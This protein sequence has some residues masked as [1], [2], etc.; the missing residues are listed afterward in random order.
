MAWPP[1]GGEEG[2]VGTVRGVCR[3]VLAGCLLA[4][5][6]AAAQVPA[7]LPDRV[8]FRT[9]TES[10]NSHWYVALRDGRIWVKPNE[11]IGLRPPGHWALLG[12]TGL[13]EG[14]GLVRWE[15]PE[16]VAELSADGCHLH[17]LSTDGVFYRGTDLRRD[18]HRAFQ[19]TDRWGWP[20]ARGEGLTAGFST[21][22]GWDVSD[23]HPF[24]VDHYEDVLGIE[25]SVGLGVAHVYRLSPDGTRIHYN[26]WWL[27]ADWSRQVCGPQRGAFR[28]ASIS[29]S[30]ST[31]FVVGEDGA[32]YTRLFD[33]DTAGENDLLTYSYVLDGPA[34]TTRA[35]PAEPW[36]RQPDIT[37]G[38][39]TDRITIFQD[40]EGNAARVLRVEGRL[41]EATGFFHKHLRDHEWRFHETGLPLQ[42]RSVGG[43][44]VVEARTRGA[45]LTGTLRR[46]DLDVSLGV[47][48]LDFD[49][50]CS[51]A[52]VRLTFDGRSLTAGG[53]PLTLVL[54]HVH[55]MVDEVRPV[56]YGDQ[57][58]PARIRGALLVPPDV[59]RI[60]DPAAREA[61]AALV[62]AREVID[63]EGEAWV[64]GL[65]LGE[66]VRGTPFRVPFG[67]KGTKGR[68]FTLVA[69]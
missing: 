33:F 36:A 8:H 53:E 27:P 25:H 51:P 59:A 10:F 47:E 44:P 61:V 57:G 34:G 32:L 18:V 23:S 62:G 19:W 28:A 65:D 50:V 48:V 21:A 43:E 22:R 67:E 11:E 38:A 45:A 54:H 16:A 1:R 41:G 60:D 17:A 40:G 7:D 4:V 15:P 35:L 13:P 37:G 69:D 30:G 29:A 66:I 20:M 68:R 2:E 58:Q 64:D 55:A 46:E 5:V 42:G 52:T 6:G 39:I 14:P 26:D 24:D 12:D 9:R 49:L 3:G 31:L 56:D 63:L